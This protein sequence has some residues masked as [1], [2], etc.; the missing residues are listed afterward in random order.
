MVYDFSIKQ[1]CTAY[2]LPLLPAHNALKILDLAG[3]IEYTEE[4]DNRSRLM[5][6]VYRD[7]L[8]HYDF[9]KQYEL[10]IN[11][12]LRLYTGLFTN[13]A[14]ID[15]SEIALRM[16]TTREHV[17]EMFKTLTKRNVLDY[18]PHKK[19]PLIAYIQPRIESKYL[20]IPRIV[21]EDRKDRFEKRIQAMNHY[22]EQA[23]ICRSRI[24]LS[25]FGEKDTKD[26][27]Q[28]DICLSAKDKDLSG[29][30]Y[31]EIAVAIKELLSE[32]KTIAFIVESLSNYAQKD[33]IEVIRFMA[34]RRE[35]F[36]KA[37]KIELSNKN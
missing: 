34:D 2:K 35:I 4:I 24:L 20:T 11:T 15:E 31:N 14:T 29:N 19:T 21:N 30:R 10:L 8:Y 9:D 7:E 32:E 17:Y 1:F 23:E 33:I 22:A 18:I 12:T 36:L 6:T 27:G 13:Y 28:C 37:D 3:Y 25:Y 26:C 5:F 16:E